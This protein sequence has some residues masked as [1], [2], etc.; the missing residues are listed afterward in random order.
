M[1]RVDRGWRLSIAVCGLA[2]L[3]AG[4]SSIP[5]A[6][7]TSGEITSQERAA[8]AHEGYIIVDID[9]RVA[10]ILSREPRPTLYGTFSDRRPRPD[11]RVGVGDGLSVTIW[12]AS[13]GGLFSSAVVDR[14]TPG[15]RTATIPEQI[16][17]QD[18]TIQVPYAGRVRAAGRRP[19]DIEQAINDAL[20][21]KA[22]EPQSVV[23]IT[24]NLSNTVTLTGEVTNGAML[25]LSVNGERILSAIAAAGGIR[26]AAHE[27]FIRLT[28]G[29]KT[30]SVAFNKILAAPQENI[31]LRPGDVVTVVREPQSFTAFGGTQRNASI[32][33]DATGI[34][35]EQAIAKTGGL[36]DNRADAS[37]VFMLRFEPAAVAAAL[38]PPPDGRYSTDFVPVVYRLNLRDANSYFLASTI[39]VRNKD[40]L[41]VANAPMNELQKVLTLVGQLTQPVISGASVAI[42]A[43][44][45]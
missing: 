10:S 13:Q 11:I 26:G 38:Q 37:G 36:L 33:F 14:A 2:G 42:A 27:S 31:F 35:L 15:S 24:R 8:D 6:G 41:Y 29:G 44:N 17:A 20:R 43:G 30:A 12:E 23:T 18:G 16:V 40:I 22:I 34:T 5:S 7:P 19:A 21:G 3:L 1:S 28:R 45:N 32:P 25:P 9:Q 4:C 39:P